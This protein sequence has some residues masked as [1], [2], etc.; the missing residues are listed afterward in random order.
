[1][2]KMESEEEN[3]ETPQDEDSDEGGQVY[4]GEF[5]LIRKLSE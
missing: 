5:K 3:E 4:I 1:V 2:A